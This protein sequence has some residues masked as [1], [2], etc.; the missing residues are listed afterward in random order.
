[1]L[2]KIMRLTLFLFVSFRLVSAR[3]LFNDNV[4]WRGLSNPSPVVQSRD[5]HQQEERSTKNFRFLTEKTESFQV[6]SL[7]DVPFDV[8]ELY[9][10]LIPIDVKNASRALFFVF[11]P[12]IG[13]PVDE[14]TIWLNGGPGCSS[15]EGF[16]QEN[17]RFIWSSGSYT[18][19][20]NPYSWVNLTNVLWVEQ[21]VGTGFSIGQVTAKSQE[22][23]AKDFVDFFLNFQTTFGIK[24][25]KIFVTGE[26]YAGRYVP[27]ISAAMIAEKNNTYFNLSGALVYDPC[28]GS[29]D[30]VQEEVVIYPYLQKY[31]SIL[32]IDPTAMAIFESLDKSCG[33]KDFRDK[34]LTF[35]PP[36]VQPPEYFSFENDSTCDIWN[37]AIYAGWAANPCFNFYH[38]T[39]QCPLSSDPLGFPTS[40]RVAT[41]GLP[42]YFDRADVKKAMHAPSIS[43]TICSVNPV[44]VG[45]P[46][47]EEL[48]FD[49]SPDPI[50]G[51]LPIVIDHTK[52]VLVSN[53]ALDMIIISDGTLLAIQNM[54]WGGKLG[55]QAK[56]NTP[57]NI[58]LPDLQYQ[59]IFASNML[60]GADDPQ[61]I[62]GTQHFER[63]LM[64]AATDLAGHQQPGFQPRSSYRHLQWLLGHIETL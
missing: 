45:Q 36:G 33:Y 59:A 47:P 43:W 23:I 2:S 37:D 58:T 11:Q 61:G 63:G 6:T 55:F 49:E 10:G 7:P 26:S 28:I 50:Q 60:V 46:G 16:F 12:T 21:P 25:F 34:Y 30:Y 53:A 42:P 57:I 32:N 52:R 1:M 48:E 56:P 27:Y 40:L 3:R 4:H 18:P 9:S 64:W 31:N 35:P 54:T 17:G 38:I 13:A 8:G 20:E 62:M 39:D 24:N 14:I 19:V 22:D 41:P 51:V 44:F 15:L 29:F 5:K